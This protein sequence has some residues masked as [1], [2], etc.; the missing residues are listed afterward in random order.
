MAVATTK[1]LWVRTLFA[2]IGMS[3]AVAPTIFCDNL[4]AAYLG[5]NLV[6]HDHTKHIQIDFH[7]MHD[8]A[9]K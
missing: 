9:Q 3:L 4:N 7:F 6:F 2:E 1:V 5:H 8:L